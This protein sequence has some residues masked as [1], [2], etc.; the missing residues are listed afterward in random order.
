[1][2]TRKTGT[3]KGRTTTGRGAKPS[4]SKPASKSGRPTSRTEKPTSRTE[5]PAVRGGK[6]A[7]ISDR[8]RKEN[9]EAPRSTSSKPEGTEETSKHIFKPKVRK[10]DPL[11]TFNEDAVRLNKYLS[12]AG[13]CSRREAD[14]LIQTGV[15]SVNGE[16]IT[17]MGYKIKPGDKIQYD[18]ETINAETKRYVLLNKPKGFITT[19]DDPL[20]RKTVMGLVIKACKER[21]YPVGRLD[22][23]TTGLLLFTNDGDMA[24]KLT[25]PR[26]EATK[27]YHVEVDKP[28]QSEHL[29]QLMSGIELEDGTIKADKA[30][31]VKDGKSSREVG[32]EIHSGKN[33][34]VRRMFEKL[35]YEVVKLDRVQFASLTK[36]DL[37]R[38]YYRHLTE[39]EVHFLKMT[40]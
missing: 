5:K 25:H 19:M 28:V 15:V 31:Y 29:E 27:I 6:P 36:K 21:I 10:G 7:P 3:G 33:R 20:G 9:P 2:N 26:Y 14:V 17:E 4:G 40:K 30:E 1:M 37:P 23:D 38:G 12:N 13:V 24:K 39:K 16:V 35:G 8:T 18:G 34:I 22:R 32:V 11:P